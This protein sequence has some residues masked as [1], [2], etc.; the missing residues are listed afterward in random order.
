MDEVLLEQANKRV[1]AQAAAGHLQTAALEATLERSR[2]QVE[3]L[4]LTAA[5][6]EASIPHQVGVA[7]R[8]GFRTEVLPVGRQIAEMRG[9]LN[10]AIRRLERL[11]G[12]LLAE[13]YARVEDLEL[14]VALVSE[15]WRSLDARLDRSEQAQAEAMTRIIAAIEDLPAFDAEGKPVGRFVAA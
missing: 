4:G 15:S 7:V 2:K 5:E 9:L 12:E 8:E 1:A 3:D 10:Q 11:E 14:L 13:R 6:L